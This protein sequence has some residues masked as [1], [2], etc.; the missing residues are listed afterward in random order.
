M[1]LMYFLDAP[2]EVCSSFILSQLKVV[3]KSGIS[4]E[5]FSDKTSAKHTHA[6]DHEHKTSVDAVL[7]CKD[8]VIID[9]RD[10]AN[11]WIRLFLSRGDAI[12]LPADLYRK[13]AHASRDMCALYWINGVD[14][15]H[16]KIVYRYTEPSDANDVV[17]YHG[18]RDLVCEL[19]T[20]FFTSGWVTGTGGSI[21]I[22]H[23]NR[24]YMTPSGVQ[25]ERIKPDELYVLDVGGNILSVPIRK[26]GDRPPKLSDCAP[27]FLHA[28]QQRGAGAV[29]HSHAYCTN[30]ITSIFEGRSE[31][32]VSHQEMI[33]GMY[34]MLYFLSIFLILISND[35][36]TIDCACRL[37][38][39]WIL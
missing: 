5:Y 35:I 27:L 8:D 16:H 1:K 11:C 7:V 26:P 34:F 23:G 29:L 24:I 22:R 19:C 30:L 36:V 21:S 2:N 14:S 15:S 13:V 17:V 18:Y 4:E 37:A 32:V 31:F 25:K 3:V 6:L 10:S 39:I 12:E 38:R 9:I 20:Q 28:F 33:K